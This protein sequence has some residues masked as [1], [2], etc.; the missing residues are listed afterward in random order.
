MDGYGKIAG[1]LNGKRYVKKGQQMLA[2]RVSWMIHFGDIPEG[3]GHHGMV[4][5][6]KCDNPSCV[7]PK[8]LVLG[9]QADNV[10]DAIAKRRAT[11]PAASRV[12][13]KR[14]QRKNSGVVDPDFNPRRGEAN[15]RAKLTE[16]DVREIKRMIRDNVKRQTIA[17]KFNISIEAIH[18]IRKGVRWGWV[19]I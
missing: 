4:V 17:A 5:M 15:G 6:H 13:I 2:H 18:T 14:T 10:A 9:T 16:D 11:H 3:E 1:I 7:N 8:H 19:T 12:Q